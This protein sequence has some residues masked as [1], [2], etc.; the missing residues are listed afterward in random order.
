MFPFST[1]M[2][3]GLAQMSFLEHRPLVM[4]TFCLTCLLVPYMVFGVFPLLNRHFHA[5]LH[6]GERP[7]QTPSEDGIR[8]DTT[9]A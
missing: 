9:P 2:S 7:A 8:A 5:W 6:G 3:Y 1:A 4:R